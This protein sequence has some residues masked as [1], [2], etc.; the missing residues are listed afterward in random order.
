[1]TAKIRRDMSLCMALLPLRLLEGYSFILLFFYS[2]IL[3]VFVIILFCVFA[4]MLAWIRTVGY[5]YTCICLY[6]IY[7]YTDVLDFMI[8][9][10]GS[11]QLVKHVSS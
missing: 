2:F 8:R 1:M 11:S 3:S 6:Y 9:F 7:I 10:V 4:D 5:I